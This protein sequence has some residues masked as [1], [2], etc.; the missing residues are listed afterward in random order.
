MAELGSYY[1]T[2]MPDMSKFTGEVKSAMGDQGTVGGKSFGSGFTDV[3]KGSAFGTALGNLATRAGDAIMGGL[4]KGIERLDT[5]EN[6]PRV[7]EAFGYSTQEA[8]TAVNLIMEHLRGLPTSTQDMVQLTQAIS[9]STGDLDL[10]SRAALGF[11]DM[12]LAAGA[13]TA[14]M[15]TA[16]AV[17]NRILG[18]GS[19]TT[20][21]WQS[22]MAV[23]PKQLDLVAES[24]LGAGSSSMDLYE[25]LNDG[26]VGWNDFLAAIARMDTEGTGSIKSFYEQA[27]ANSIGI[28]SAIENITNRIAAGWA[29]VLKVL[30]QQNIH[31]VLENIADGFKGA[32]DTVA[33]GLQFL[34]DRIAETKI[35]ENIGKIFDSIREAVGKLADSGAFERIADM[36]VNL[37]DKGLQ[38]IVDH[39]DLVATLLTSIGAAMAFKQALGAANSILGVANGLKTLGNVLPMVSKLG[40]IGP[41]FSLAAEA[42]GPLKGVFSGISGVATKLLTPIKALFPAFS[43]LAAPIGIAV[44]AV[45]GLAAV[46]KTLWDTSETFRDTMTAIWEQLTS[47]IAAAGE[48]IGTALAGLVEKFA[49]VTDKLG[50]FWNWFCQVLEPGITIAIDT[51]ANV[52]GGVVE[53]I[54]GVI[55]TIAGLIEGFTTGNWEPFCQ[56][57]NNLWLGVWNTLSAPVQAVF[58]AVTGT[59]GEM[60]TWISQKW[61]ELKTNVSNTVSN[62]GAAISNGFTTMKTTVQNT[63]SNMANAATNLWNQ[64][65]ANVGNIVQGIMNDVSQKWNTIKTNV[66]NTVQNIQSAVTNAWN[67][68]KTNIGNV[69]SGITSTV[70]SGFSNIQN[71]ASTIFNAV[72][73]TISS[74][75][76]TAKSVVSGGLSA[77][78]GFFSGCV[79][80]LPHIPLPHFSISG[81]FSIIPPS[82]PHISVSWYKHGGIFDAAT[83]IGIGEGGREAA[84]PLNRRSYSEI[85]RGI[86]RE[87]AGGGVTLAGTYYIREEADIE[88][89]AARLNRKIQ[90][91][92][93]GAMA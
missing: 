6:F 87:G 20:A 92:R 28:G 22:L 70:Q 81:S 84:L 19:A 11:N 60:N 48:R 37:I 33:N 65:K 34:K 7:M 13:S 38:W 45:A 63:V 42:G 8:D 30:G 82:V 29:N 69:I 41:A 35:G 47:R 90:R 79:L 80:Q 67:T 53:T 71:T 40:D 83:I 76:E 62:L 14:D 26:T 74:V 61:E 12:M 93:M 91:E 9:D 31:D 58:D 78:S 39:G 89:V 44:A 51:I 18:K 16:Q 50:E 52:I 68:I 27:K 86:V 77:I 54:A 73:N 66:S 75:M 23:M 64:F 24:M 55:E 72:G 46:I 15:S 17:L 49:P 57:I 43:G 1:I 32:L 56:A 59:V 3:L 88:R 2:I 4:G 85:A 10:A 5:L 21:Q 25:A 36:L